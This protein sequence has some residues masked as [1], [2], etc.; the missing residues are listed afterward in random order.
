LEEAVAITVNHQADTEV[1]AGQ[2]LIPTVD[3]EDRETLE[4]TVQV[5]RIPLEAMEQQV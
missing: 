3:M 1:L 2:E 4:A 5:P